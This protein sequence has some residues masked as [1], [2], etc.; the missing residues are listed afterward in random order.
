M[1]RQPDAVTPEYIEARRLGVLVRTPIENVAFFKAE[2]KAV[3]AYTKSNGSFVL[4]IP[5]HQIAE[6]LKGKMTQVHRSHL[7]ASNI[8]PGL[9]HWRSGTIWVFEIK[10]V[11]RRA[12]GAIGMLAHSIPISRP[13]TREV[14]KLLTKEKA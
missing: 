6:T 8:M 3:V 12:D 4:D 1:T 2:D 10:T 11:V 14:R 9:S 5:L 13:L 7:V